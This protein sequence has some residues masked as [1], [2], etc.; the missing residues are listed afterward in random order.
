MTNN[1]CQKI[2]RRQNHIYILKRTV[3]EHFKCL[4]LLKNAQLFP[5]HQCNNMYS[6][7]LS[8]RNR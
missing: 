8:A 2:P 7:T 3:R 1:D 5:G 6:M 4:E